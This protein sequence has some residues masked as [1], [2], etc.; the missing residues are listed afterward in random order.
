MLGLGIAGVLPCMTMPIHGG[1][2]HGESV[3]QAWPFDG[4]NPVTTRNR[5]VI[6]FSDYDHQTA[7][8]IFE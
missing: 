6:I 4:D 1:T 7:H 5:F 8:G 2:S 3:S